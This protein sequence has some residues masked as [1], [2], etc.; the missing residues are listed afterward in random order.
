M[1]TFFPKST[2]QPIPPHDTKSIPDIL[3]D[4]YTRHSWV[5]PVRGT[6]PWIHCTGAI[7]I[8]D[9]SFRKVLPSPASLS[10][11]GYPSQVTWTKD[12]LQ[13]FWNFLLCVRT[14]FS[15]GPLA[16]SFHCAFE[17]SPSTSTIE[18][19]RI[20]PDSQIDTP[21]SEAGRSCGTSILDVDHI[22][23]Y[24]D[25]PNTIGL[26][27]VL[28]AWSFEYTEQPIEL[29]PHAEQIKT[30]DGG[31]GGLRKKIRVLRG[32]RLVLLDERGRGLMT[33]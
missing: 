6:P 23:V 27:N 7:V 32:A 22:K 9:D 5:I 25:S 33:C 13:S 8:P 26:R 28:N 19:Q 31:A 1:A 30:T 15:V 20:L 10:A 14:A 2:P 4:Q 17:A 16:L 21:M 24:H 29:L 11:P 3:G 12:S 18:P